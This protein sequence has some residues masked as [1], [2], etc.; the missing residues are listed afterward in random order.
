MPTNHQKKSTVRVAVVVTPGGP[1]A[2]Q[3]EDRIVVE[4]AP[5]DVAIV[6]EAAAVNP[7][8]VQTRS[9]IYHALGWVSS[10]TV[11][12]GWDVVG[13]IAAVG[14]DV[15]TLKVGQRVAALM[16][17]VDRSSGAYAD[18]VVV[19]AADVAL[20]PAGLSSPDAATIPLNGTTAHQALGL[21]G[22]ADGRRLLITG[23][24]GAV[25]GYA[26]EL[27]TRQGFR[28][29]GLARP[30]DEDFVRRSGGIFTEQLSK[31]SIFDAVLD[32]AVIGES[33]LAHVADGG[34]Y[35]GVV[36][37]S[38]PASTRGISTQAVLATADGQLLGRLLVAAAAGELTARVAKILPL[39]EA[40]EAHRLLEEGGM[41][42]RLVLVP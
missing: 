11:G 15:R 9:G 7:V 23:A 13:T 39:S 31:D 21:L 28:V 18:Q 5:T 4:P 3:F 17:G 24:G 8:D 27:A 42:G 36:P 33:V 19:P 20:V 2:I 6:V 1:E 30:R 10:P 29:T 34:M 12:L 37:I 41:R 16:G 14:A 32:A 22:K 25:G 40:R 38:V 26:V 35:V